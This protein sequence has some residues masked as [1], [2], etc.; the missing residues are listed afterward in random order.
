MCYVKERWK[1]WGGGVI[2]V[3]FVS[4]T[5]YSWFV[6]VSVITLLIMMMIIPIMIMMILLA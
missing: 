3:P 2:Y 1:G 5:S 6:V 4:R